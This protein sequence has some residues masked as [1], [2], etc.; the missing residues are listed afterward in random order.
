MKDCDYCLGLHLILLYDSSQ[1]YIFKLRDRGGGVPNGFQ[2]MPGD[3]V[4]E[5]IL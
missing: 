4:F 3:L 5:C 1:S 2:L